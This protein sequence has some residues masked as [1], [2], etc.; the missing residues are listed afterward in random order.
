MK[1]IFRYLSCI[2]WHGE[3][4]YKPI[5]PGPDISEIVYECK[6][7]GYRKTFWHPFN[8]IPGIATSFKGVRTTAFI[9]RD[10]NG[11]LWL[12]YEKPSKNITD[13]YWDASSD[14]ATQIESSLFPNVDWNDSEPT[15]VEVIIKNKED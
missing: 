13:G 12:C 7:C 1:R 6:R 4:D 11:I 10:K 14:I 8:G 5:A 3:H 15:E 2:L 9:V